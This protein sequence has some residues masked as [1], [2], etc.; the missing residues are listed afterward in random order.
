MYIRQ[1]RVEGA[2]LLSRQ[3]IEEAVYPYLGPERGPNDVDQARA[4]LEKAYLDKGYQTVSVEIPQQMVRRGIVLLKVTEAKVGRLRVKGSRYY[5]LDQIKA[6]APSLREGSVPNFN[7][8]QK[9]IVAL[10]QLADRRVTP[11][12][13]PGMEPGTVDVDLTVQDSMPLHGSAELNNRYS[14]NTTSLRVNGALSYANL[15][16]LGHSLGANFQI[17][18]ERPKDSEVYSGYYQ[19]RFQDVDWLSLMVQATKQESDVATVGTLDSIGRGE[20]VGIRAIFT[21]PQVKDLFQSLTL[22]FTWKHHQE[23]AL[24]LD[25]G[26]GPS[27]T[28]DST[29]GFNDR[30]SGTPWLTYYP[31]NIDY[32]ASVTG[33]NAVTEF[34][35][36]L[37]FNPRGAG[38]NDVVYDAERFNAR[39]NFFYIRGDLSHT[40]D[41]PAG[42]EIFGK[43]QG[44]IAD[45]PLLPSEQISGGGLGT[46]R[47][48]LESEVVGDS[49]I[50]GELEL[51]SPS[52]I[53]KPGDK[54]NEWR[55]YVFSDAGHLSVRDPLPEQDSSFDLASFG[56][57][58]WI[59][60]KDHYNG[61]LDAGFPLI[62]QSPTKAGDVRL[63]F[64]IWAEF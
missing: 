35:A 64:R 39:G 59:R 48:Y 9:D 52:L 24:G 53:G 12:L 29:T 46:V 41:L 30:I 2:H 7:D 6:K 23:G 51:R 62:D 42:L 1:Y 18:P 11:S 5:S 44:Q 43:V 61:S 15:W 56:I 58:S 34:N 47:G 19:A 49:A 22:G 36:S 17:A 31:L 57:G 28:P 26:G 63:T 14:P 40:H 27:G 4:A 13:K 25:S 3:E 32:N 10:N 37:V 38:S 50:F 8:V 33:S 60:F 55:F 54:S 21:L 16:Q 20:D 45:Q